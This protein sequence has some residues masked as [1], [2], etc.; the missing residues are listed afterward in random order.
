MIAKDVQQE[1]PASMIAE[2]SEQRSVRS[3]DR[4]V[5]SSIANGIPAGQPQAKNAKARDPTLIQYRQQT[6]LQHYYHNSYPKCP[7][8]NRI[9]G[10]LSS[11]RENF[12]ILFTLFFPSSLLRFSIMIPMILSIFN[13]RCY[14]VQQKVFQFWF[15][16]YFIIFF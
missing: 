4:S 12:F 2:V 3:I 10:P 6:R 1:R 16:F 5:T 11:M 13:L 7:I 8:A 15:F 9:L 14:D